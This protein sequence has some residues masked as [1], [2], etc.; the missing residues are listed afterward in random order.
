MTGLDRDVGLCGWEQQLEALL[1]KY[2][3]AGVGECGLD[4]GTWRIDGWMDR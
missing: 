1:L 4:K 2:P 3:L